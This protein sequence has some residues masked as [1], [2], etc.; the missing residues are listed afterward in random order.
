[1]SAPNR[2]RQDKETSMAEL[3]VKL[4]SFEIGTLASLLRI[5]LRQ[6]VRVLE[7]LQ[8]LRHVVAGFL[9]AF[10]VPLAALGGEKVA[11]I[12]VDGAGQPADRIGDRMDDVAAE[13]LGIA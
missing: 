13:R 5:E 6:R 3:A 7:Q 9:Q 11:A 10:R 2:L 8:V 12:D 1:M 4:A